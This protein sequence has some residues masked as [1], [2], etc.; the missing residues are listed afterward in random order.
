MP[1]TTKD[2]AVKQR[3]SPKE[4]R[5]AFLKAGYDIT[6]KTIREW[7]R[8]KELKG[9]RKMNGRWFIPPESVQQMCE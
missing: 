3:I 8:T 9:A 4:A 7:C 6:E 1:V 5:A 2:S